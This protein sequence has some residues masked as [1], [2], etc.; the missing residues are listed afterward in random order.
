MTTALANTRDAPPAPTSAPRPEHAARRGGVLHAL[1]GAPAFGYIGPNW[2]ASVMGTGIVAVAL[3]GLPIQI[4]GAGVV[5]AGV[6]VLAAVVLVVVT[7][8]TAAHLCLHPRTAASHL[9]DPVM[10]HF[11]GAPAMALMTVG[12]GAMVAG[13]RVI[14]S[15][16]ALIVDAVLWTTGTAFGLVTAVLVPYRAVTTHEVREDSAFGGWLM[17]VV[18]PMVSAATGALLV[19][20]LPAGQPRETMLLTCY[21][22]FGLTLMVSFVMIAFIWKRLLRHGPGPAGAVPTIWIV[23]GPVGQSITAA[24][25]L[26]QV[27]PTIVPGVYGKGFQGLTLVFGIPMWGFAMMW[28]SLALLLTLRTARDAHHGLPFTLTWW[29]FTFPLGTVVT[30]TSA[31][32]VVTGLDLLKVAAVILFAGLALAWVTVFVLT[33]RGVHSGRL[34]TAPVR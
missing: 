3:S 20:H 7:L 18:P 30:G 17:P 4:P 14:G 34:L 19:P 21:M 24:H 16:P 15:G 11:Y 8:A 28:L 26:G 31:L 10:S 12:A 2:F 25:H 1:Q 22:F 32:A 27:A 5:A 23:L 29:S 6:W 33:L 13:Y 9:A